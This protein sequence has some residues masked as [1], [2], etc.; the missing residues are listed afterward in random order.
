MEADCLALL[1]VELHAMNVLMLDCTAEILAV[2]G[3]RESVRRIFTYDVVAVYE[4]EISS[5]IDSG[6][7]W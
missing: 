1:W 3:S 5:P 6:K 2:R 4:V 7:Q